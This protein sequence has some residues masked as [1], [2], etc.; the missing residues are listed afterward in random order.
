MQPNLLKI[1]LPGPLDKLVPSTFYSHSARPRNAWLLSYKISDHHF[2]RVGILT[3][4]F[5]RLP[6][7]TTS[8][9][10]PIAFILC[11]CF[12]MSYTPFVRLC[13]GFV[14]RRFVNPI[15]AR[16]MASQRKH[17]VLVTR[18]VPQA[19]IEIL[20]TSQRYS[21]IVCLIMQL[22]RC[23]P[24]KNRFAL[25]KVYLNLYTCTELRS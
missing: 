1:L 21:V 24:S 19:A 5:D 9:F 22:I 18:T 16:N 25:R 8:F 12:A 11:A 23:N 2:I 4:T 7:G 17:K 6:F 20:K 10:F 3:F 15:V 13:R 14:G